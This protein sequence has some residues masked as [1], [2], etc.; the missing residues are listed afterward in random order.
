VLINRGQPLTHRRLISADCCLWRQIEFEVAQ[1]AANLLR[2]LYLTVVPF[3]LQ[4]TDTGG[5]GD[6]PQQ[7]IAAAP[8]AAIGK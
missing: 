4:T 5:F 7:V 1:A 6:A 8:L 2:D 3:L